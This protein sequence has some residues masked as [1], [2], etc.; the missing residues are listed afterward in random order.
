MPYATLSD[1]QEA[2]GEAEA[3]RLT[4][5]EGEL[6]GPVVEAKVTRALAEA[7]DLVD[8]YLAR[9]YAVPLAAPVAPAI[10]RATLVLAR[11][12]LAHGDQREPTEQMRLARKETIAWL[13]RLAGGE[14]VLPGNPA[15]AG[16]SGAGARRTDRDR[17]FSTGNLGGW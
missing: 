16:A 15:L 3:I 10:V 1:L 17:A 2:F 8:S 9:R 5:P 13:E 12:D 7:S 4:A 6:D 11:F 14:A